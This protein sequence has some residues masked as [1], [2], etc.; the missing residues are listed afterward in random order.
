MKIL[1]EGGATYDFKDNLNQTVMFYLCRNGHKKTIQYLIS[2]GCRIDEQDFFG[3]TPVF[4][5]A[6]QNH[7]DIM[8]IFPNKSKHS[9]T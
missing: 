3:Q 5:A 2:K 6:A 1:I 4:Y 9:K 7:L 8:D